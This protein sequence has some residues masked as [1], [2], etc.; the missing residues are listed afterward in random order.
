M[1]EVMT[2]PS[3]WTR[4]QALRTAGAF[5]GAAMLGSGLGPLGASA[6][7]SSSTQ[8]ETPRKGGTLHLA[9]TDTSASEKLDPANPAYGSQFVLFG[10]LYNRLI[11]ADYLTWELHPELAESWEASNDLR[12]YRIKLRKG[13]EFHNGKP[14]TA[15]DVVW[16]LRRILDPKVGSSAYDRATMSMTKAGLKAT[17]KH[18]VELRLTRPDSQL[19]HL[20]SRAQLVIVP[21]GASKFDVK[22]SIGTGPFKLESW[23]AA[24]SW[25]VSANKS[26]WEPG[27]PHLDAI[28]QVITTDSAARVDGV[29]SRQFDLAEEIE[30]SSAKTV[31]K[32]SDIKLFAFPKGISRLVV[33]DC[34]KK[35][36]TDVRV[37]QAFK[38]AMNRDLAVNS[39][40]AGFAKPT[41]DILLPPDDPFYPKGLGVRPYD[42]EKAKHLLA[43]A[44]YKDGIKLPIRASSVYSGF[45]SLAQAYSQSAAPAG[46]K[47]D[48]QLSAPATYFDQV[49]LK[50]PLYMTYWATF[51][52]P[53]PL[54]YFYAPKAAY[55]EAHIKLPKVT[56][57]FNAI[58]GT[59]DRAKQVRLTQSVLSMLA[60]DWGHIVPANAQSPWVGSPRLRGVVGDPPAFRVKLTRAYFAS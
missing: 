2:E 22:T 26:Y 15:A 35:P 44:G 39:V 10:L 59:T 43:S 9:L 37:R 33:M 3:R 45:S 36:F 53:D 7:A 49:W 21:N 46:I 4:E 31:Q 47:A 17:D 51:F 50:A 32:Q 11:S 12:R 40:Y 23:Q 58:M 14:L 57:A 6:L 27:L 54:W 16:S 56:A 18:T 24:T 52:P 55:N 28:Q 1:D 38:Y 25:S 29:K 48:V 19:P 41:T 42:P 5:A 60:Q 20:L 34:S 13:V 8:G 30:F